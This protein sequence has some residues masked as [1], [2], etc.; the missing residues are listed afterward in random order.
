[1][2]KPVYIAIVLAAGT[3]SALLA[4]RGMRRGYQQRGSVDLTLFNLFLGAIAIWSFGNGLQIMMPQLAWQIAFNKLAYFGIAPLPVYWF[5]FCAFY[6]GVFTRW[7]HLYLTLFAIPL[8]TLLLV[9]TNDFHG[10][11]WASSHLD[12]SAGF[13]VHEAMYGNWFNLVHT[14]YSYVM[15]GLSFAVLLRALFTT[16]RGDRKKIALLYLAAALPIMT[17]ILLLFEVVPTKLDPTPLAFAASGAVLAYGMSRWQIGTHRPLA[18]QDI[19]VNLHEAVLVLDEEQQVVDLNPRAESLLGLSAVHVGVAVSRVLVMEASLW[20]H[21]RGGRKVEITLAGRALELS[22]TALEHSSRGATQLL[23]VTDISERRA[24]EAQLVVQLERLNAVVDASDSLRNL[25]KRQDVYA[26]TLKLVWELCG[27]TVAT[28]LQFDSC[29]QKLTIAACYVDGT[30]DTDLIGR[31]FGA[32]T[33]LSWGVV[34]ANESLRISQQDGLKSAFKVS[35]LALP[36]DYLGV[37]LKDKNGNLLGVVTASL[38]EATARFSNEDIAFIEA[39]AMACGSATVRLSLLEEAE[40]Q[41]DRYLTLYTEAARQAQELSLLERIRTVIT[42]QLELDEVISTTVNAIFEIAGYGLVSMY[43]L[44]DDKTTLELQHQLGYTKLASSLPASTGILGRV[45][46]TRQAILLTE[47]QED[48]ESGRCDS[49]FAAGPD[50]MS[51]QIAVP[52][53]DAATVI[54]VLNI[55]KRGAQKLSQFDLELMIKLSEKVSIAAQRARLYHEVQAKSERLQLLADNMSDLIC[56][57]DVKGNFIYLTP[58]CQTVTGYEAEE[59]S[60]RSPLEL[61]HPDDARFVKTT[62][63]KRLMAGQEVRPFTLRVRQKS[64]KYVWLE[65]FL[66]TVYDAR[67]RIEHFVSAA[68]DVTERKQMQEQ[69]IQGAL[70]YDTLTNLPNR[71]LFMDRL[72]H[73][74]K[75][76]EQQA[77]AYL[78]SVLF[79]DL[80]RFKV[81]N[82]SLGH[83]AGDRLL[84]EAS[85]RLQKCVRAQDTVARLGGDEFAILL[86]GMAEAE[87]SELARR[88]QEELAKPFLLDGHTVFS[89]ASIGITLGQEVSDPEQLLRNADLAM[90]Q[91]KANGKARYALFDY[92][93]HQ[94]MTELLSLE[95]DLRR[96][97]E[98][99]ELQVVYQPVIDLMDG[100]LS[101]FEALVRWHHPCRGVIS[102]ATFIPIAEE[103]GI[104]ADIDAFVLRQACQQLSN[105]QRHFKLGQHLTMSS[106]LST[107][108]FVLRDLSEHVAAVLK[109]TGILPAQLKLE[110]TE[111]VLVDNAS[112]ARDILTKLRAQGIALQIDD[113]G[114]GYSSLSYLHQLPLDSLKIDRSFVHNLS[115]QD[116]AIVRTIISLARSLNLDVVAE[117]IED[118]SQLEQLSDLGCDYGQGFLFSKPLYPQ[119]IERQFFVAKSAAA[120]SKAAHPD[121]VPAQPVQAVLVSD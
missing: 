37:P 36:T 33:C 30:P 45:V 87:A 13:A 86:E 49:G 59:L 53:F 25:T 8:L 27:A 98:L 72:Q 106:N 85:R 14:P 20:S 3:L 18:Y 99:N 103:M 109:D 41:A 91:A 121:L 67:G 52:V 35:G 113:F 26:A 47:T 89:S 56:L 84:I 12:M 94:R 43:L 96:A 118:Y 82:D 73:A 44:S 5:L 22:Q 88:V 31:Q 54:G 71:A 92:A 65:C 63:V 60:G 79:L 62:V 107:K 10:L 70:L 105:W 76:A 17:N 32:D 93:M 101:G 38:S 50:A 61:F 90:Y 112:V 46:Q 51:S 11:V 9:L 24:A 58:S 7:R 2:L 111:S 116:D 48:R 95:S 34:E 55:E 108:N 83:S 21:L 77:D 57:H 16:Q 64:G 104:V 120:P 23:T 80:D 39:I 1:M 97:L 100:Q 29:Q 40:T 42:Q 66:Q 110:I 114:T 117:G 68:R 4:W 75:H 19:F 6:T 69:M 81:I 119:E 28:V 74:V 15:I 102:P 115:Q 78:F